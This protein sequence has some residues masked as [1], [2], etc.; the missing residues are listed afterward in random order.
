MRCHHLPSPA[1]CKVFELGIDDANE[2]E[3]LFAPPAFELFFPSDGF[4]N[5]FVTLKVE[6]ALAA[7]GRSE[8]FLS[9]LLMLHD[10]QIQVA[11]DA[12]VK[13]ACMAA[14]NLDVAAGHGKMLAVLVLGPR[15]RPWRV[16]PVRASLVEKLR[17]V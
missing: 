11:G 16:R 5:V 15:E 9:A 2:V 3:L 14:E 17:T 10:A 8:T 7:I 12:N 13:R 1:L 6:Q 4:A